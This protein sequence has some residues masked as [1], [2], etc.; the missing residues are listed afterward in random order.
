[1]AVITLRLIKGEPLTFEEVDANFNNLNAD[2]LEK[3]LYSAPN[4]ML[5]TNGS[6]EVVP[7]SIPEVRI[8]GRLTGGQ[9]K[10]LTMSELKA[11]LALEM[12]D[13]NGLED[14]LEAID[15]NVDIAD[16]GGLQAA[17][18]AL[19]ASIAAIRQLPTGGAARN[20]VRRTAEGY[21]WGAECDLR[22]CIT[23]S[24]AT[25][26]NLTA[27]QNGHIV[28]LNNGAAITCNIPT[29]LPIGFNCLI[30]QRGAG[31]ITMAL[32][33]GVTLLNELNHTK[34]SG[35]RAVATLAVIESNVLI[36]TGGTAE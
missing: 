17:L 21:V 12:S 33:E 26:F 29:G 20:I 27:D 15:L 13:V 2:K 28:V 19:N 36:F 3:G 32:A 11:I 18:D 1:M 9:V 22:S 16:V 8:V 7:I 10:A 6:G 24:T 4:V 5:A 30:V 23:S 14:A 35:I 25:T 34:T 31:Q